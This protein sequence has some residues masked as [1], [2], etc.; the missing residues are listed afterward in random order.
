M[1]LPG[2]SL[3]C[4]TPATCL[5]PLHGVGSVVASHLAGSMTNAAAGAV[6]G[7]V[8]ASMTSAADWLVGHVMGLID[9]SHRH[10]FLLGWFRTEAGVMETVVVM[11]L[12]PV[13]MVASIGPVLRQDLRRLFRVWGVG[14]PVAVLAGVAASQLAGLALRVTDEMCAGFLGGNGRRLALSF[15]QAMATGAV[16]TAPV[17]VK[18]LLASVMVVGAVLVWL[19]MMVRS[20]AVYVAVFFMPLVLVGY[21]WPSTAVM[22]RRGVE[23]LVSL[24]LAK[25][26]IVATLS[27]GLSAL[28]THGIDAGIAGGGLMLLAGFAPF[29]LMR[30][31]PV[32]EAAAIGHLEGVSR[33]PLRAAGRVAG[34][35]AAVPSHP[36]SQLLLSGFSG[37][38]GGSG[39]G[40]S[41][42]PSSVAAQALAPRAADYPL[43]DDP[44]TGSPGGGGPAGG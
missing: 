27:L 13:L 2:P 42:A 23:I 17:F 15:S 40:A 30:I 28:G 35:A 34:S 31:T 1:I 39:G 22:A 26:V 7:V 10:R 6:L 37:G 18:M 33:R 20:A 9:V 38:A 14:L 16:S 25:F 32:V 43:P 24:I 44:A 41:T 5:T 29:T 3:A 19:E 12:L 36:V 4:P 11:A 21:I 8:G